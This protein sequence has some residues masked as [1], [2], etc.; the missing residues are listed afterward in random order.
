M[1]LT[2]TPEGGAV[3]RLTASGMLQRTEFE[4]FQAALAREIAAH[5][6]LRLLVILE[7]FEGWGPGDNWSDLSFY[8]T[9]GDSIERIAIVGDERW[10]SEMLMFAVADL[11]KAPVEFFPASRLAEARA[12]LSQ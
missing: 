8:M 11:R 3:Y 5:G 4:Q 1:A 7:R 12:W 10:R 9:H 2:M 6:H